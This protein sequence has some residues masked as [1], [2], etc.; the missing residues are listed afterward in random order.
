MDSPAPAEGL[1][2]T[3]LFAGPGTPEEQ[4]DREGGPTHVIYRARDRVEIQHYPDPNTCPEPSWFIHDLKD[5]TGPKIEELVRERPA[6]EPSVEPSYEARLKLRDKIVNVLKAA[7][8]DV[9]IIELKDHTSRPEPFP[10]PAIHFNTPG[11]RAV[12][13]ELELFFMDRGIDFCLYA[14]WLP[15]PEPLAGWGYREFTSE[16]LLARVEEAVTW[17][18]EPRFPTHPDD[19]DDTDRPW[20]P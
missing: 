9:E 6:L 5:V 1:P 7:I 14:E 16:A 10:W 13:R 3:V 20:L 18:P 2:E 12:D 17:Q 15:D 8:P 19:L 11:L 4:W